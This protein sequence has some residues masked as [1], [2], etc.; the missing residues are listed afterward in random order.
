M[1]EYAL[2]QIKD[3]KYNL[4][5]SRVTVWTLGTFAGYGKVDT[6]NGYLL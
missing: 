1:L 4:K 5:G 6:K 2:R 3:P